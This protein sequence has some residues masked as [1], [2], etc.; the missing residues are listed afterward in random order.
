MNAYLEIEG[1]MTDEER[2]ILLE[3]V[4]DAYPRLRG[5][6]VADVLELYDQSDSLLDV[7]EPFLESVRGRW[8]NADLVRVASVAAAILRPADM[9]PLVERLLT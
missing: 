2:E 7:R 3:R 5:A 1:R 6:H 9:L 4:F 8:S